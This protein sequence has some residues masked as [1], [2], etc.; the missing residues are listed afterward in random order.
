MYRLRRSVTIFSAR[1]CQNAKNIYENR[2]AE[3]EI[4]ITYDA[5]SDMLEMMSPPPEEPSENADAT[6][7][8]ISETEGRIA[9]AKMAANDPMNKSNLS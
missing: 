3:T 5:I 4:I 6:F 2:N 8:M 7:P 9:P 1:C